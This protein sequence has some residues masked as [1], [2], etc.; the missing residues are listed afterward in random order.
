[1][2]LIDKYRPNTKSESDFHK[3]V[4]DMLEIM[5]KDNAIPHLILYGP[6]GSGK[7]TI[8]NIFLEMLFGKN[9]H[10]TKDISY[11]IV[12]SGGKKTTE[13]V[14]QSN[15]HIEINPKGTNY[16]RYLIHDIVKEYAKSKSLNT[17]F[18]KNKQFK[19]VLI[20][21]VDNLS[22]GAQMALRRTMEVYSD[23]C[24]F[25]MWCKSLSK[26]I[27]ELQS[28]CIK[29]R[30][31]A[32]TDSEIFRYIF[33]VSIKEKTYLKLD[34]YSTIVSKANGNIKQAL[35][36]LQFVK[37]GYTVNTE[38]KKTL[39]KIV[40]YLLEARLDNIKN[41]RECFFHLMITNFTGTTILRDLV[42]K[43]YISPYLTKETKQ[44]IV[45]KGAEIEYKL[46]KGRRE[47]IHLDAF[48]MCA[49]D[50]IYHQKDNDD[51][52]CRNVIK[53]L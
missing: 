6:D 25:I 27:K 9:V 49:I 37:F 17:I 39:D 12:S 24:R 22:P 11:E 46:M 18:E 20:N 30:I 47:I 34:E 45:S 4:I 48:M 44:K 50:T 32:P 40:E 15:Y 19:L 53:I 1:M 5:S 51:V 21:N 29:Q 23:K 38:Y 52:S 28:R 42:D 8:I 26:L 43:I 7:R 14:R 13:K 36:E 41:I 35:W 31:P 33:K 10:N 2:F 16:D 3:D